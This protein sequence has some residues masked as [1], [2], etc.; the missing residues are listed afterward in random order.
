M[1]ML[2]DAQKEA[3]SK[4]Y[5][6]RF[7]SNKDGRG[8][9][10]A[11]IK[12]Q[13]VYCE[14]AKEAPAPKKGKKAQRKQQEAVLLPGRHEPAKQAPAESA[15]GS[16]LDR[17]G[18]SSKPP[19][20]D[21]AKK[22]EKAEKTKEAPSEKSRGKKSEKLS[23]VAVPVAD[24]ASAQDRTSLLETDGAGEEGVAGGLVALG[25]VSGGGDGESMRDRDPSW[26]SKR[27]H[28]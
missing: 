10:A 18:S 24:R 17:S 16:G 4:D 25:D 26:K 1:L 28:R 12:K 3:L 11:I 21:G 2:D 15:A 22:E 7:L 23:Q 8:K 5:K 19:R 27:S 14:P 9:Y 6:R 20:H 13:S